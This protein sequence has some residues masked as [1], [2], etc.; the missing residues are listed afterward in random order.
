MF[1]TP[2]ESVYANR[3]NRTSLSAGTLNTR[4][5]NAMGTQYESFQQVTNNNNNTVGGINMNSNVLQNTKTIP[6]E[7]NMKDELATRMRWLKEDREASQQYMETYMNQKNAIQKGTIMNTTNVPINPDEKYNRSTLRHNNQNTR[8]DP[9][10]VEMYKRNMK[11]RERN[12]SIKPGQVIVDG[13][14][15][16]P[17]SKE[18]FIQKKLY[19]EMNHINKLE[20]KAMNNAKQSASM[21]MSGHQAITKQKQFSQPITRRSEI[22]REEYQAP[23]Q[24]TKVNIF[25]KMKSM[26]DQKKDSYANEGYRNQ[27]ADPNDAIYTTFN[28]PMDTCDTSVSGRPR[29]YDTTTLRVSDNVQSPAALQMSRA[30]NDNLFYQLNWLN[31]ER[32]AAYNRITN[33]VLVNLLQNDKSSYFTADERSPFGI[34][35]APPPNPDCSG[36]SNNPDYYQPRDQ[37]REE[38]YVSPI[39]RNPNVLSAPQPQPHTQPQPHGQSTQQSKKETYRHIRYQT[40]DFSP[41]VKPVQSAQTQENYTPKQEKYTPKTSLNINKLR[42]G[43]KGVTTL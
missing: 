3:P 2:K 37:P 36:P 15:T 16:R 25:N 22:S 38:Q 43:S 32:I 30:V 19:A 11:T 41:N 24:T 4:I 12:I 33:P 35:G 20:E 6:M 23:P 21:Q 8:A 18:E 9:A 34:Y 31:G 39:N 5:G 14:L 29:I 1:N 26:N 17:E 7:K 13:G 28:K 40:Q 10:E 27:C 42:T